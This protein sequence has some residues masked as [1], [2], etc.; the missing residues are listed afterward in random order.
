MLDSRVSAG[1]EANIS[2]VRAILR[3][4]IFSSRGSEHPLYLSALTE[5]TI[6]VNDLVGK[7]AA[8]GH[9]IDF[10]DDV[11]KHGEVLDV[12]SLI[13]F[14]RNAVCHVSSETHKLDNLNAWISFNSQIGKG[15]FMEINGQRLE[16][17][18][19]DDIAFFF[20][21]QRIYLRRHLLRA[22]EEAGA[23]LV[24]MLWRPESGA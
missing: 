6:R 7:A 19:E 2:R 5:L 17:N 15:C 23:A 16:C 24:P 10:D 9:T 4:D 22:F 12:R 14:I 1:V 13:N 20:G 8:T 18:Y 11:I 21:E 3:S